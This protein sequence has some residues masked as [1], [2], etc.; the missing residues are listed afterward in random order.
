VIYVANVDEESIHGND[1]TKELQRIA[2]LEGAELVIV[3]AALE[4]QIAE[5]DTIEEKKEFLA[6]YGLNE[7]GLNQLIKASYHLLDLI[8][9]FTA[10]PQEVRAWTIHRGWKAPRAAGVIHTDFEKGFIKAEVIKFEDYINYKSEHACK[11][12][13]KLFIEGRE[14]IVQDGDIMHFRFNV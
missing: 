13:G 14:Y 5:L 2:D 3:C 11:E 8:T 4:A 9:Y 7:S 6:E 10:G 12:A 1:M